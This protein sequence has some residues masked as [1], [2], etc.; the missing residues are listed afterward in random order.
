MSSSYHPE[1]DGKTE[2]INHYLEAYLHYFTSEQQRCW[3][4]WLAWL[5]YYFNMSFY[6]ETGYILFE[7][8]YGQS[9]TVLSQFLL[10]EVCVTWSWMSWAH[11]M[12]SFGIW[13]F[14]W[15]RSKIRCDRDI[16]IGAMSISRLGTVFLKFRPYRHASLFR[17]LNVKLAPQFFGPFEILERISPTA[18]KLKLP[19]GACLHPVFHVSQL[20]V[21]VGC[22]VVESSLTPNF[23]WWHARVQAIVCVSLAET[24][25]GDDRVGQLLVSWDGL[26]SDDATWADENVSRA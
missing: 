8:V 22:N 17:R 26:S 7:A 14:S 23:L 6:M 13:N 19:D 12:P 24:W 10:G 20:K 18:Y 2:V 21:M 1:T 9:P 16:N 15:R 11:G 25:H 5:E 3:A 4:Q